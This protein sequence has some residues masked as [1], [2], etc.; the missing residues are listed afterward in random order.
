MNVTLPS[1]IQS[2]VSLLSGKVREVWLI[3]SRAN[4][5][6]TSESDWDLLIF[7]NESLLMELESWPEVEN[8]D[9][10]VV[11]DGN[12]FRSPWIAAADGSLKSGTLSAWHWEIKVDGEAAYEGTKWPNDWGSTKK[13]KRLFP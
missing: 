5:T 9:V 3:G 10:L 7:A 8:V 2:F 4:G 12:A 13:A 1:H 6:Q 11:Y